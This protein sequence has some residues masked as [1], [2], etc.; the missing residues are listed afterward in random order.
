MRHFLSVTA[1]VAVV[2]VSLVASSNTAYAHERRMVGKYQLVVGFLLEPAYAGALGQGVDLRITDTTTTPPKP[3]E[4]V[5]ATLKVDVTSGGLAPFP[6]TLVTRFGMP[7][8]YAGYFVP[9]QEGA[10]AF[11]FK[12]KIES[13][14]VDE[15]F[16]SGP[17]RF[18]DVQSTAALEYPVKVP[19]AVDLNR[20]LGEV[21]SAV[22]QTR[23]LALGGV[24]LGIV[25]IAASVLMRRRA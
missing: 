23:L 22:D 2:V 14:D 12:G 4:G 19:S 18:N 8:A 24:V 25:A 9:T 20:R 21:Q 7:G 10:Y 11:R 5:A 1:A 17:G 13:L 15:K 16:E 6:V 3:V